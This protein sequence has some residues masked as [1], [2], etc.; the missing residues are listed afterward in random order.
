MHQVVHME[1]HMIQIVIVY[2]VM[3]NQVVVVTQVK[4][5]I[6]VIVLVIQNVIGQMQNVN[7]VMVNAIN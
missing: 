1:K 7:Q 6:Q 2:V 5:G 4:L 3:E